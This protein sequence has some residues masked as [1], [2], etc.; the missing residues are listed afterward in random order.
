M[1]KNTLKKFLSTIIV[2][3]FIGS[4]FISVSASITF[5][6][7]NKSKTLNIQKTGFNDN[8]FDTKISF[9]MKFATFIL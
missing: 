2:I 6:K 8:L 4:S 5:D 1:K 7:Q 3:L 9:L